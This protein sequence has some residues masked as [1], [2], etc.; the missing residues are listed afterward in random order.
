MKSAE[1]SETSMCVRSPAWRSRTSRSKP[2][3]APSA[4][5]SASRPSSSHQVE[6]NHA[7][8]PRPRAAPPRA[9]RSPGRELQ[10][11]VEER[12]G[13]RLLLG[14]RLHLDQ[15]VVAGHH[16]VHVRVGRRV[17][18]VVEV[19]HRH[20]VDDPDRD[21]GDGADERLAEPEAVERAVRRDV[22]AADRRAARAA[23]GLE[24]VAVE[25]ERALAERLEVDHGAQRAADQPLD[26]DRAPALLPARRLA[27]GAIARRGGQER[28]LGGEP[29]AALPVEP[30]RHALLDRGRAEHAGAPLRVEHR[31]VRQLE[32]VGLEVERAQLV[33]AS[34]VSALIRPPT[35]AR[36]GDVLDLADRQLQEALAHRAERARGRRS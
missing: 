22:R 32:E 11:L 13:E 35:P 27:V 15:A 30:A 24:D 36:R 7:A 6:A 10:Q 29:A 25:P 31:A 20:A 34:P 26:L 12:A 16:D 28:V 9:A 17:L 2:T 4:A 23:V 19:E 14:G 18:R 33:G 3:A 5:A 8:P 21:G 1:P